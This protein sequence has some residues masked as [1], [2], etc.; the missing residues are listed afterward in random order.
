MKNIIRLMRP[1]H[2]VKNLL[3]FFPLVFSGQLANWALLGRTALAFASF[4]LLCSVVYVVNDIR[5]ADSDRRHST[6]R[7]RPIASGAVSVQTAWALAG[8][9]LVASLALHF[10]CLRLGGVSLWCTAFPLIYLA[11]NVAYSF[12]LKN[13]P[14]L[15]VAIL[16]AGFLIR[17][18]YGA[19]ADGIAVSNWLYL[20]VTSAAFFMGLGKRRGELKRELE[21]RKVLKYYTPEF[22]DKSMHMCLTLAIVFYSLWSADDA[23]AA[24]IGAE[25]ARLVWTVPLVILIALRYDMLLDGASDGDPVEVVFRDKWLLLMALAFALVCLAILYL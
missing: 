24:R 22:L 13:V 16:A 8:G 23:T 20:T 1:R 19:A 4:C 14:L 5:D 7:T 11:M 6:K 10:A 18:L 2:Y 12:G 17:V 15:D 9:L 3:I 21:G 25:G